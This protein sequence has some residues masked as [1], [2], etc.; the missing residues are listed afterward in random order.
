MRVLAI[1]SAYSGCSLVFTDSGLA[2]GLAHFAQEHGLAA[3]LPGLLTTVLSEARDAPELIAVC[4]GPGSFTGLR[5]GLSLATGLGLA[6]SVPVVGVAVAEAF[7]A[8]LNTPGRSLWVAIEARRDRLFLDT[9]PGVQAVAANDLP[10]PPGPVAVAGNAA[11]LVAATL[12]ARGA[13][14][15]LTDA[16][17]APAQAIAIVGEQRLR[18]HVPPMPP[19][20]LYID[21]PEAKLPAGGLRPAP[22]GAII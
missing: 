20:P 17:L 5:A 22:R 10:P 1:N 21:A 9:G 13:N 3:A 7:R 15:M 18:G 19:L 8:F 2:V 4:V 14:V 12:A 6:L 11:A 16:R